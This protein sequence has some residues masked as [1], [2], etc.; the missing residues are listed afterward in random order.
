MQNFIVVLH[1]PIWHE[2]MNK[3]CFFYCLYKSLSHKY[4]CCIWWTIE[5]EHFVMKK[6]AT[7][8]LPSCLFR[9]HLDQHF[10]LFLCGLPLAILN[11]TVRHLSTPSAPILW[12]RGMDMP[13]GHMFFCF[14]EEIVY[15][16][17]S[18]TGEGEGDVRF[19]F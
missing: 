8:N 4:Y 6:E 9:Q 11:P 2:P 5:Y 1:N 3:Y 18:F 14:P 12:G 15:A 17:S 19:C 10:V 16:N 13:F 7:T